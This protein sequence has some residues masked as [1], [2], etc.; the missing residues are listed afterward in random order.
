M[1]FYYWLSMIGLMV[2][3]CWLLTYGPAYLSYYLRDMDME[4]FKL[5]T[6]LFYGLLGAFVFLGHALLS[7]LFCEQRLFLEVAGVDKIAITNTVDGKIVETRMAKVPLTDLRQYGNDIKRW[8]NA[9]KANPALLANVQ[10][11]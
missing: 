4:D 2:L 6:Y 10:L 11:L 8:V 1:K 7:K 9:A 3:F 5:C